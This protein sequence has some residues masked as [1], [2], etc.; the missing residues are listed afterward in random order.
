M[1]LKN[2]F[3]KILDY[4]LKEFNVEKDEFANENLR[5]IPIKAR[6]NSSGKFF[7]GIIYGFI[8]WLL[9]PI[10]IIIS[11]VMTFIVIA[12]VVAVLSAFFV[13]TV[14]YDAIQA[15]GVLV[16]ILLTP[17]ISFLGI[18]LTLSIFFDTR[19]SA[20][21]FRLNTQ[22]DLRKDSRDPVLYLRS[23]LTD[24]EENVQ[25]ISKRT[26]EEDLNSVLQDLGPV[27]AVGRPEDKESQLGAKRIYM[28]TDGWEK[29]V[30]NLMNISQLIII[31]AGTSE[32]LLWEMEAAKK[33]DLPSKIIISF[34]SWEL[35]SEDNRQ[36]HYEIFK[37]KFE[38]KLEIKLPDTIGKSKFMV[39]DRNWTPNFIETSEWKKFFFCFSPSTILRET[40][41]PQFKQQGLYLNRVKT[42][43]YF[44]LYGV[45]TLLTLTVV[46]F[47]LQIIPLH[48]R[49]FYTKF[50]ER[51]VIS[52]S[53]LLTLRQ[54]S[55]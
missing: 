22:R 29:T 43:F 24:T 32:S 40:L 4:N 25:K 3:S 36:I 12:I 53:T 46:P 20:K 6:S 16:V 49:Y 2:Y 26:P 14:F 1:K 51:R 37:E 13:N 41:R 10:G 44:I 8:S 39:F 28:E 9:L 7:D 54:L 48:F 45:I 30:Q 47:P 21:K 5:K 31:H 19:R 15:G 42:S 11:L 33:K 55:K 35:F 34:L 38:E 50:K 27:L 18:R 52:H 23:Y 17:V